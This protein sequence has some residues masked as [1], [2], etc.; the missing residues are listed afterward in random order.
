MKLVAWY[1]V[2]E[3]ERRIQHSGGAP[4]RRG[5]ASKS[6]FAREGVKQARGQC[7]RKDIERDISRVRSNAHA[8]KVEKAEPIKEVNGGM[9]ADA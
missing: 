3:H 2:D 7:T 6:R 1:V 4:Q 8:E 5:K 9:Y